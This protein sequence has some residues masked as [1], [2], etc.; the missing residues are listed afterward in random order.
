MKVLTNEI[1]KE[2]VLKNTNA[3]TAT[4][5]ITRQ[6]PVYDHLQ[7]LNVRGLN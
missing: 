5:S 1:D 4:K 2:K 3:K 7:Y 6:N